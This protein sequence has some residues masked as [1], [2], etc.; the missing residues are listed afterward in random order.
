MRLAEIAK[1]IEA[2][3][4]AD[5][6]KSGEIE[7]HSVAPIEQ[8]GP[9]SLSFIAS[10]EYEKYAAETKAS[11]I[12]TRQ[13]VENCPVPQL[14][15]KNPYL[16]FAKIALTFYKPEHGFQGISSQAYVA[17]TAVIEEEVTVFPFAY[18]GPGAHI[19]KGSIIY[20]G[21]YIGSNVS[22]GSHTTVFA[23]AVIYDRCK[24]GKQV[25]V[26][27]A[28]IIGADGFGF[29]KGD[30]QIVKIPQTG[31]VVIEDDVEVGASTT[32]DRATMG[33][34][35]IKRGTKLDSQVHI[36]HNVEVG[37]Y[38]LFSAQ[39]GIAGSAKI[40]NWVTAGGNAGFNGHIEVKDG[41]T[42][43]AKA[44][45]TAGIGPGGVFMGFP[46]IPAQEWRR[47][48]VYVKRLPDYEKRVKE[49]EKRLAELEKRLQ[50]S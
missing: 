6:G 48:H 45:V 9:G 38:C 43:G 29:A 13:A 37:E 42:V 25:I 19:G 24:L 26:H 32:I 46:A 18:I 41:V 15:H 50:L 8:A 47:Q 33:E 16:A 2:E 23:N 4:V 35:R 20:P 1:L 39:T 40:G 7:I 3:L 27:S 34:T 14:L 31:I 49:L 11:A 22:I 21:A 10:A 44:G 17:E 12:I 36:A 28:A 30:G 5:N